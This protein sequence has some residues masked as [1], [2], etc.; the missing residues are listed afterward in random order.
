MGIRATKQSAL[1]LQ[2][3]WISLYSTSSSDLVI[4]C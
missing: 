1:Q 3:L 4:M 2:M